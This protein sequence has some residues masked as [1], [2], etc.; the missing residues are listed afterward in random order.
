MKLGAPNILWPVFVCALLLMNPGG[1]AAQEHAAVQPT[2]EAPAP[3]PE[4][5]HLAD[6]IPRATTL[7]ARLAQLETTL[8]TS[9]DPSDVQKQLLE[10][11]SSLKNYAAELQKLKTKS[12]AGSDQLMKLKLEMT[13]MAEVL[14][15]I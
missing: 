13:S 12:V 10:I 5:P 15:G 1:L 9:S 2:S 7:A 14:E 3:L 8:K 4:V 11:D 6:L